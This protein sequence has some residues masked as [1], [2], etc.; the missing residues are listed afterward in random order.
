[1]P[2]VVLLRQSPEALAAATAGATRAVNTSLAANYC[3]KLQQVTSQAAAQAGLAVADTAAIRT[4]EQ[5]ARKPSATDSAAA[6]LVRV[7]LESS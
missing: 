3:S 7:S 5:E 1:M 2:P 4:N 6:N